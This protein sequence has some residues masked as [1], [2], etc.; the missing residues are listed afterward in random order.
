MSHGEPVLRD[1]GRA[2]AASLARP[3]WSRSSLY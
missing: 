3:P 2:L 1:G